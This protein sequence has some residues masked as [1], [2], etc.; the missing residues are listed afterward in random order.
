METQHKICLKQYEYTMENNFNNAQTIYRYIKS[1]SFCY[2]RNIEQQTIYIVGYGINIISFNLLN[3]LCSWNCY[4]LHRSHINFVDQGIY[5]GYCS[6]S[7]CVY[8]V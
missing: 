6:E 7:L 5:V 3:G 8:I 1:R 2:I 4:L